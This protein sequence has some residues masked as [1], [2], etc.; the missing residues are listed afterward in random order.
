MA[1]E[2]GLKAQIKRDI[3]AA[4]QISERSREMY[5]RELNGTLNRGAFYSFSAPSGRDQDHR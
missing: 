2:N 1:M 4:S 3:A 5:L